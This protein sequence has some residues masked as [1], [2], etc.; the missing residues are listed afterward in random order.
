[1]QRAFVPVMVVV[2]FAP[3][4]CDNGDVVYLPEDDGGADSA[5]AS[6]GSNFDGALDATGAS[7]GSALDGL[8][9]GGGDATAAIDGAMLDAVAGDSAADTTPSD[10]SIEAAD[11]S[12]PPVD[13]EAGLSDAEAGGSIASRLLLSYNGTTNSELVAFDVASGTVAGRLEYPGFIGTSYVGA[14]EPWLLEQFRDVVAELD[15]TQPWLVRGSWNVALTDAV[16]GGSSYSDPVAAIVGTATKAYVLRYT[17][18]EIAV[19][20]TSHGADAALPIGS[21]D[22]SGLVQ[23][24]GDGTVEMTAG[25][26]DPGRERVYVLLANINRT[27][28]ASDG[29]TLL[30]SNTHPTVVAIDVTSDSIVDLNGPADGVAIAL[31]GF[32]PAWGQGALVYDSTADRLLV[33]HAG[34]NGVA[35]GGAAGALQ[36]RGVEEVSL[37]A[38]TTTMLLDLDDEAYP[39]GLVYVDAHHAF[40]QLDTV[41]TW[42]PTIP[43][44][45]VPVPNAPQAY[46]WDGNGNLVGVAPRNGSDGG[47]V[48]WDVVSVRVSDGMVTKLGADPFSLTGGFLSGAQLWPRP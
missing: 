5:L 16:D 47:P 48:G 2:V 25:V 30:C 12:S 35:E 42:D 10:S 18:N 17:R 32:N 23:A 8:G 11:V 14:G 33:L 21:I 22:L 40:V 3:C 26:Y 29:Y 7:D 27:L 1:M 39:Q 44:L 28:V 31:Q 34:C 36:N 6:D 20:D 43:T 15:P 45:G 4:A 24:G 41:Y 37:F 9:D 19:I 38:A 46:D 13:G